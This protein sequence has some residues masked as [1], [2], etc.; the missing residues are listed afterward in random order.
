MRGGREPDRTFR[1]VGSLVVSLSE[2][3]QI[4]V[5]NPWHP[6]FVL[7]VVD[8]REP[9]AVGLLLFLFLGKAVVQAMFLVLREV[10]DGVFVD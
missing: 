5:F 7:V 4:H 1:H 8:L 10:L 6:L 3:S 9:F 2:P